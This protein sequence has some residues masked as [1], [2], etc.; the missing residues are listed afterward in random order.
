MAIKYGQIDSNI[1]LT[2]AFFVNAAMLIIAAAVFHY[3]KDRN[4]GVADIT[5]AYRLLEPALGNKVA[6][7]LFAV[8]LLCSG[9]QATITGTNPYSHIILAVSDTL[10]FDYCLMFLA[11]LSSLSTCWLRLACAPCDLPSSSYS[12]P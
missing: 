10:F 12:G 3:G 5:T 1:S 11:R 8:A 9:Q 7:K 2:F 6:P 4:T